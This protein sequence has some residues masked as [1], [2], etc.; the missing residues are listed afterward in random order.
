MKG[1]ILAGGNGSRLFPATLA[2]S[3]Q[4]LAVFDKPMIYYPLGV[5]MLAGIREVLIISTPTDL[6]RFEAMLG[7]GSAYGLSLSY[8][9]QAQ[10]NGL[11][12]AFI[13]GREF[14][15]DGPAA[16][17]LGDNIFYGAGLI[18][19]LRQAATRTEGATVFA[20]AVEDP[21]RYGVVAFDAD[22]GTA[23]S[24]EEKPSEPKSNW[25]VTGL[26]FYDNDV[27]D[28]AAGLKPS[29]RGELEISDVNRAY[30]DRGTLNVMRLGRGFAWLDTGTHDSLHDASSYVR[31]IEKRQG[32]KVMCL[33]EIAL[34]LGYLTPAQ[35]TARADCLGKTEYAAYLR[36]RASEVGVA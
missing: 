20:Y 4:L 6:P 2:V 24:I 11:A 9:E 21:E 3:K 26:Y 19:M 28:I 31:T 32:L 27:L 35:V 7:D 12:E 14:I 16:L 15:G 29:K 36:R 25:A 23:T 33:E 22:T 1:I 10:P 13:I 17:I 30:L 8:A 34:E 18:E 5:L